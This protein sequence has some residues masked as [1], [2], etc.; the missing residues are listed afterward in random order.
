VLSVIQVL[1]AEL[2]ELDAGEGMLLA[3]GFEDAF[4]GFARRFGWHEPV[5]VYDYTRCL[6]IL[7]ERDGMDHLGA[8]EFFEFNVIGAW[9]GDQTPIFIVGAQLDA[10]HEH[11]RLLAD[12]EKTHGDDPI[13]ELE[14]P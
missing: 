4:V 1:E 8:S 5:A 6:E 14:L 7:V 9:V 3:D 2:D 12:E 11:Y 10:V 13:D